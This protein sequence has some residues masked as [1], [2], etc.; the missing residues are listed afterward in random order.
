MKT[1]FCVEKPPHNADLLLAKLIFHVQEQ[2][3]IAA[4]EQS[5][6]PIELRRRFLQA[7]P[8]KSFCKQVVQPNSGPSQVPA[9]GQNIGE[10]HSL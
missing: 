7:L 6:W 4:A 9:L 8:A 5:H 3:W 10:S 1:K 2:L